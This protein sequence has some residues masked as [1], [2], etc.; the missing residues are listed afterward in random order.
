MEVRNGGLWRR[1]GSTRGVSLGIGIRK[2]DDGTITNAH[3]TTSTF[4]TT[5]TSNSSGSI[6]NIIISDNKNPSTDAASHVL[7]KLDVNSK[8]LFDQVW[9]KSINLSSSS[10]STSSACNGQQHNAD[11]DRRDIAD[12]TG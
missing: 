4:P 9:R 12:E 3:N 2:G 8:Q 11:C 7:V 5:T 10:S 6:N 1:P